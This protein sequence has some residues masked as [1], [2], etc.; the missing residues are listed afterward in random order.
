MRMVNGSWLRKFVAIKPH[1]TDITLDKP[2]TA[3]DWRLNVVTSDNG[4]PWK[5]I[6]I[7]NWKMYE[8]A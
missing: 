3:Q 7:Y 8:K 6:R 2:I 4:A 5:A 1:V